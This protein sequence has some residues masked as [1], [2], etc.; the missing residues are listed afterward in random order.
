MANSNTGIE[1]PDIS[2]EPTMAG[3][4]IQHHGW[5][6]LIWAAS[7][8][9]S[10]LTTRLVLISTD[11]V[12]TDTLLLVHLLSALLL[13]VLIDGPTNF[14]SS[15]KTWLSLKNIGGTYAQIRR[16][17]WFSRLWTTLYILSASLGLICG[18]RAVAA[19]QNLPVFV[20]LMQLDCIFR[21][22]FF[23][24]IGWMWD[25]GNRDARLPGE[26]PWLSDAWLAYEVASVLVFGWLCWI[27]SSI[28]L[29]GV[30]LAFVSSAMVG[31]S[32]WF[33]YLAT[34]DA[35]S[36]DSNR[37][38]LRGFDMITLCAN[39]IAVVVLKL[40]HGDT[41]SLDAFSIPSTSAALLAFNTVAS[42]LAIHTNGGTFRQLRTPSMDNGIFPGKIAGALVWIQILLA[43]EMDLSGSLGQSTSMLIVYVFV[44]GGKEPIEDIRRA[45]SIAWEWMSQKMG[46]EPCQ[47]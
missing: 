11:V 8:C 47:S 18:Y 28:S 43:V 39:V 30:L 2:I 4:T 45:M 9:T 14:F 42:A 44:L 12:E 37:D 33:R 36:I 10:V 1:K 7:S 31:L 22:L 16:S 26:V 15:V 38:G 6:P 29:T 41:F 46:R 25:R 17:V 34:R 5:K 35:Q 20:L 40:M 24:V 21:D 13:H 32:P 3:E 19:L 23:A 27:Y